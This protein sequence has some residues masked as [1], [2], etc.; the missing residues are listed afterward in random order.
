LLAGVD[1]LDGHTTRAGA[2]VHPALLSHAVLGTAAVALTGLVAFEAFG[3]AVALAAL[4]LA[5]FYPVMIETSATI[6][7]EKLFVVL[8]L[9]GAANVQGLQTVSG[10]RLREL[11]SGWPR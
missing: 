8:D 6:L 9:G 10:Q 5:A 1:L 7:A 11:L 4:V 2:S 3:G